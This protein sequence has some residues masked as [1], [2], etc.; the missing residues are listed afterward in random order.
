MKA[1]KKLRV[2][3]MLGMFMTCYGV[4]RSENF[5]TI[6]S[7]YQNMPHQVNSLLS[8]QQRFELIEYYKAGQG[9]SI[10]N[11][12]GNWAQLLE[13]DVENKHIKVMH[14]DGVLLEMMLFENKQDSTLSIG[15]IETICSPI[16][17]STIKFYDDKWKLQKTLNNTF[18][19]YDF[20]DK[21][22]IIQ[23]DAINKDDVEKDLAPIFISATFEKGGKHII[24]RNETINLLQQKEQEKYEVHV[25]P[26]AIDVPR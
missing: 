22:G 17:N 14:T 16:C 26:L 10:K 12:F 18:S 4:T 5:G 19:A 21:A 23:D 6:E 2:I 3:V 1:S 11:M 20:L 25:R 24:L 8:P 9:D 15:V 13:L 7:I